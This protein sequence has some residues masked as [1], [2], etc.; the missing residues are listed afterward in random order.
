MKRKTLWHALRIIC[1]IGVIISHSL[2]IL[3]RGDYGDVHLLVPSIAGS[4]WSHLRSESKQLE[5]SIGIMLCNN[6]VTGSQRRFNLRPE[7]RQINKVK[8]KTNCAGF[9]SLAHPITIRAR[10]EIHLVFRIVWWV[11]HR[12]TTCSCKFLHAH[13]LQTPQTLQNHQALGTSAPNHPTCP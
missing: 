4:T 13:P 2:S 10:I 1:V 7:I 3:I 5:Q 9:Y 12:V 11:I 6:T 8:N